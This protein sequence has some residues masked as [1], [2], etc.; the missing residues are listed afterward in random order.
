MKGMDYKGTGLSSRNPRRSLPPPRPE[1]I[2]PGSWVVA[3]EWTRVDAFWRQ[4]A[5]DGLDADNGVMGGS[6]VIPWFLDQVSFGGLLLFWSLSFVNSFA[7]IWTI[8]HL[9]P[10]S[11]GFPRQEYWSGLPFTS[12]G[13]L[14]N[15]RIKPASPSSASGFFSIEQPGK[16]SFGGWEHFKIKS[17]I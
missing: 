16:P 13:D 8:A 12:P 3:V 11:M 5:Q 14:P 4:N 17:S 15:P 6:S 1:V 10:L 2:V 9:A 7:T